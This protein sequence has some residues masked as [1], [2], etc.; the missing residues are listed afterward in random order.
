MYQK[1]S[2]LYA[3]VHNIFWRFGHQILSLVKH[4]MIASYIGLS[5]QLD[6]FYMALAIFGVLITSWAIVFDVLAIPKFVRLQVEKKFFEFNKLCMSLLIFTFIISIL[7]T[8]IF[9]FFSD[10]IS[11]FAIGFSKE[12]KLLLQ[13]SFLWLLPA[14][15]FYLP[16][17]ALCSILKSLRLFS[18]INIIE[19]FSTLIIVI[20]LF[21][22]IKVQFVLYWSYSV[23][24]I[25]S[26]LCALFYISGKIPINF[27]NPFNKVFKKLLPSIP[28]LLLIHSSFYIFA[29]TDRFFVTFLQVGDISAL[30]YATVIVFL[31]P[32]I[33][34][35]SSFF[36]T[37][38]A[39][40]KDISKKS[41]K[42]N[43]TI[44]FTFLISIPLISILLIAGESIIFILLERGE[45]TKEDTLRVQE[46]IYA[47]SFIIIP[48]IIQSAIDQ[49]FQVEEKFIYIV[50]FKIF[51]L[52]LNVLFNYIFIFIFN[53][54][55]LG[56][57]LAT[58]VSY[59]FILILSIWNIKKV[60]L[61]ITLLGHF[62][63]VS[64]LLLFNLPILFLNK[65]SIFYS[66]NSY[67]KLIMIL[68]ASAILMSLCILFFFG[69]EKKLI[70]RSIRKIKDIVFNG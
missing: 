64:W 24:I 48:I 60:S 44:S 52:F 45:F 15:A 17:F 28:P 68:S 54:G 23:S 51:G 39:E 46:I 59:W 62:K 38:Y 70:I 40:E 27:I 29:L 67:F 16:Y 10:F 43:D 19:F 3:A 18:I 57:A 42:L 26:F 1:Q 8:I 20:T 22:F 4:I 58:T 66:L 12:K 41:I 13:E 11:N 49:I 34:G 21:I 56:A 61:S 47:L 25:F 69:P 30:T 31:T 33:L 32:Q 14:I 35:I 37:T 9:F 36:L 53:L 50:T 63:W 6:I 5:S 55:V 65:I 2:A 7:Y